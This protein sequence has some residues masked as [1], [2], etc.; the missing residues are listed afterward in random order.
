MF[1]QDVK[2]EYQ[3]LIFKSEP[4]DVKEEYDPDPV[5]ISE[6]KVIDDKFYFNNNVTKIFKSETQ[7]VKEEY[8]PEHKDPDNRSYSNDNATKTSSWEILI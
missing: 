1:K 6:H 5:N 7:D 4:Q 2:E 3:K 8:D